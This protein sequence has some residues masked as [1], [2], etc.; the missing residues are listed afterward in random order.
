MKILLVD[1]HALFREG[2]VLLLAAVMPTAIP[3][4]AGSGEEA[5]ALLAHETG[6]ELVILDLGLPG[7]S[8]FEG[9]EQLRAQHPDL[10][11]VVLSSL[12]DR[13]SVLGAIDRGAM[14]YVPKSSSSA[15]LAGALALI[16]AKS[17]YL[18]PSVFLADRAPLPAGQW[19]SLGLTAR[20]CDVLELILQGKSTKAICRDL[21]L[22]LS[23]IKI[24]T[25]AALRALNVTTRTQAVIAASRL[26][27]R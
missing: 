17:V 26:G 13:D 2:L 8:G 14:G 19:H 16:L 23:T 24:H 10:P 22:S 21:N 12:E 1:D 4:Q 6:I 20:Q 9:L 25:S 27:R 5:L 7:M 3:L 15:V 11:V 18:P